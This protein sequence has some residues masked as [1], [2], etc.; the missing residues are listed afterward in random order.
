MVP[1]QKT[2]IPPRLTTKP[3]LAPTGAGGQAT[4]PAPAGGQAAASAARWAAAS[5]AYAEVAGAGG[6]VLQRKVV[7]ADNSCLFN[8]VGYVLAGDRALSSGPGLRQVVARAILAQPDGTVLLLSRFVG[9]FL[10]NLPCADKD[11]TAESRKYRPFKRSTRPSAPP[12]P[13]RQPSARCSSAEVCTGVPRSE[14]RVCAS[15][16][17]GARRTFI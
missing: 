10:L 11:D 3:P 17:P 1:A 4:P 9:L 6:Q 2:T 7:P 16:L 5:C 15:S 8:A 14:R 12:R 13:P